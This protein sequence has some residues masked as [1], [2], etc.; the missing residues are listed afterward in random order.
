LKR[1]H[2]FEQFHYGYHI[3]SLNAAADSIICGGEEATKG[4]GGPS[5]IEMST[6]QFGVVTSAYT[7]G[8]LI[9][10]L[11]AG[12]KIGVWGQKK[13]A[14]RAAWATLIVS[15]KSSSFTAFRFAPALT[16][17]DLFSIL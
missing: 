14:E 7:V 10:S 5:C 17:T 9:A 4:W 12:D 15:T 16:H 2:L 6:F 1:S 3:S 11:N 8:G 13:T